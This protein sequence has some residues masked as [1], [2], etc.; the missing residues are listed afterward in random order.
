MSVAQS[1]LNLPFVAP[2]PPRWPLAARSLRILEVCNEFPPTVGGSETHNTGEVDFLCRRGHRVCVLAVRDIEAMVRNG[3]SEE[4]LQF[5][6]RPRWFWSDEHRVPVYEAVDRNRASTWPL[7]RQYA[8]LSRRH[9]PFDVVVVHRAHLL[10]AFA[11][12]R[13]L[14][15]TLHYL[16]L[17]CPNHVNPARCTMQPDGRCR[18]F[19]ERSV[20][21][22]LKWWARRRL[23]ARLMDAVVTKYPHLA[24]KLLASGLPASKVRC[25]PN[26]IDASLFGGRRR[27]WPGMPVGFDEWTSAGSP[28]FAYLGRLDPSHRPDMAVDAFL[29][30]AQR[31]PEARLVLIGGGPE[32]RKFRRRVWERGLGRR[33]C[34]LG[35]VPH[36][37][38]P[39]ALSWGDVGLATADQDNYGWSLL[40]MMAAR[41]PV[42]ATAVGGTGHVIEDA[43]TG[44]LCEP[45]VSE[46]AGVMERVAGQPEE[47]RRIGA[48]ARA[49]IVARFSPDNLLDYE[50]VL[51]GDQPQ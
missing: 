24:E 31:C 19:R 50:A 49:R 4:T 17:A 33:V 30:L 10:P 29:S 35:H 18:C 23:S 44:Y 7:A 2:A 42:V 6:R 12:A 21:R 11:L 32:E 15:L 8:A 16:E 37:H 45:G 9:G 22:N 36:E 25:I 39:A 40:E 46:I 14:V 1:E 5:I 48:A 38:V 47:A 26:W 3:C 43:V 20:W 27:A 28:V 51:F 34:F 13:R 41:L